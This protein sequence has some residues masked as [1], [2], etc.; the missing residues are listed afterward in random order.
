MNNLKNIQEF[1]RMPENNQ[2]QQDVFKESRT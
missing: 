2:G 1:S